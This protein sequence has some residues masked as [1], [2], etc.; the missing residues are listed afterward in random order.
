MDD[1]ELDPVAMT[2]SSILPTRAAMMLR[3]APSGSA[4]SHIMRIPC[5]DNAGAL[6][7]GC[8][9]CG[10]Q[11]PLRCIHAPTSA[12]AAPHCRGRC[13]RGPRR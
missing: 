2:A 6:H 11:S 9:L 13:A 12:T 3:S 7:P 8:L 10:A 1:V 4:K 5:T